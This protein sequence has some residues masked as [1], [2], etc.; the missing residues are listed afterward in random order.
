M[1]REPVTYSCSETCASR[2]SRPL[3]A[4]I[5]PAASAN[6]SSRGPVSS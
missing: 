5:S 3:A 1:A 2:T 4:P 6:V